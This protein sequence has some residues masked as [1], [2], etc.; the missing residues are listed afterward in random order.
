MKMQM[1]PMM[2]SP[3]MIVSHSLLTSLSVK[4]CLLVMSGVF[5]L[6]TVVLQVQDDLVSHVHQPNALAVLVIRT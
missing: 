4:C 5:L 1:M 3:L 6:Q 2:T